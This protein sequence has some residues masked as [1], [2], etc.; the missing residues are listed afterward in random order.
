MH[1]GPERVTH[2][3]NVSKNSDSKKIFLVLL[4]P[5]LGNLLVDGESGSGGEKG[6]DD[7]E[8]HC[9]YISRCYIY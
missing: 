1:T 7:S 6:G 9:C 5:Y 3:P 4:G 2:G 8:L